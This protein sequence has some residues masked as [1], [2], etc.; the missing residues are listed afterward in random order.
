[1]FVSA[2]GNFADDHVR[3]DIV[4]HSLGKSLARPPHCR[5]KDIVRHLH[6]RWVA[7]GRRPILLPATTIAWPFS[8][9]ECAIYASVRS[10]RS[11]V[12]HGLRDVRA[13]KEALYLGF[14]NVPF[15]GERA[16]ERILILLDMLIPLVD[17]AFRKAAVQEYSATAS[18]TARANCPMNLSA[19]EQEIL[20]LIYR[21]KTNFEIAA[22]LAISPFTV[23]NHVQRIF[24]KMSVSNRTE[25]AAKY[26]GA[27][28][29]PG[30]VRQCR[31]E[32]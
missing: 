31:S 9:R 22:T 1:M 4:S 19:R 15:V 13:N 5:F 30:R 32:M 14:T 26:T 12:V 24:H 25:A 11:L 7:G 23:K 28:S 17:I 2:F 3:I 29:E 10:T 8:C 16:T 21:G 27:G 18:A 20:E 6:S